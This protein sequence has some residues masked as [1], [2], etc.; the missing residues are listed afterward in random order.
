MENIG[1]YPPKPVSNLHLHTNGRLTCKYSFLA[2][3]KPQDKVMLHKVSEAYNKRLYPIC[4][5]RLTNTLPNIE[6][7]RLFAEEM[8]TISLEEDGYQI[9]DWVFNMYIPSSIIGVRPKTLHMLN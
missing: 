4:T 8:H 3:P 1:V 6:I 2:G 7:S 5:D 9:L